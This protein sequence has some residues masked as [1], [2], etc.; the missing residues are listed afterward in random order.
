MVAFDE[1][2]HT[3]QDLL[4]QD[5][6]IFSLAS[7]SLR[8]EEANEF[9]ALLGPV[10]LPEAKFKKLKKSKV[11]RNAV[12]R[13]LNSGLLTNEQVKVMVYHKSFMVT[14][15]MVDMLVE[16]LA[17]RTGTDLYV[18]GANLGL[19]NMW[20]TALPV[21]IGDKMF[22]TLQAR[23]VEMVRMPTRDTVEGF[24]HC[25][26]FLYNSGEGQIWQ[27][28][29][30][31]L[32]ATRVV[33][34]EA[35]EVGDGTALDP[36]IPAFVD[37]VHLWGEQ[38]GMFDAVQDRSKPLAQ[39]AEVLTMLMAR[40]EPEIEVGYDRRKRTFPLKATGIAFADSQVFPQIQI[41]DVVAGAVASW[42]TGVA[43]RNLDAFHKEVGDT[44]LSKLKINPVWPSDAV[45]PEA[46]GTEE[47]GG[48]NPVDYVAEL[49]ARQRAKRAHNTDPQG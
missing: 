12:I 18:R 48:V 3:G 14:T 34:H 30:A 43:R 25:V 15:K 31:L 7:V 23:F 37:L 44:I 16:T 27:D 35:V 45:T 1:S 40:D 10:G 5:Q 13:L 28:E 19:A 2:G 26:E 36:S 49:V 6:P 33:L 21:F 20:H 41:A 22:R 8:I 38:L 11:G 39:A 47:V 32:L 42:L 29:F 17:H 24:Y 46:L 9:L 4:N